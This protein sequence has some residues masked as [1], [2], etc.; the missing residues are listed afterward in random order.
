MQ[1]KRSKYITEEQAQKAVGAPSSRLCRECFKS[2]GIQSRMEIY[3]YLKNRE[4]ATVNEITAHV[5]L[6]QP[7]VSYHLH[8]MQDQ[9]LLKSNKKGKEVRFS[10]NPVCAARNKDCV[11]SNLSFDS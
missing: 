11:L 2:L 7:T 9:G 6:R 3:A 5:G 10:I 4:E 8:M 1:R